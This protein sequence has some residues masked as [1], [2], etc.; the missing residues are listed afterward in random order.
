MGLA[1]PATGAK[2]LYALVMRLDRAETV[3]VGSLGSLPMPRGLYVY[4]GSAMGKGAQSLSGRI[5]RHL[6][7]RKHVH[8]HIDSVLAVQGVTVNAVLFAESQRRLECRLVGVLALDHSARVIARGLGSSDCTQGCPSHLF[9]FPCLQLDELLD[10]VRQAFTI[11][12]VEPKTIRSICDADLR[13]PCVQ[14]SQ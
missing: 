3:K 12:N 8:W 9:F 11:L 7:R 13:I 1:L 2:G 5:R 4:M 14:A 10:L 6:S